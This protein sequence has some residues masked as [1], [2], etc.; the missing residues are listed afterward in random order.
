MVGNNGS[1]N[2]NSLQVTL[3]KRFSR[4]V[5]FQA[6]YTW[7][8][9]I[10]FGSGG[11]TQWPS[12]TPFY[13]AYDRGLSDFHHEHRFVTSGLWELPRLAGMS[14][15]VK[16]ILGGWQMSGAMTLQSGAPFSVNTGRENSLVGY[17]NR[18]DL[19]GDPSRSARADPNRDPVWEWFNTRAFAHNGPGTYGTSGRNIVFGPGLANVDMSVAKYFTFTERLQLQFRSEFF[20][21]F[22]RAN[23]NDPSNSIT[24]ATYGA[25]T[26]AMDPRIL[27]FGLKLMF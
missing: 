1:S 12:F 26:S 7:A 13:H 20:N 9:S 27:Q 16:W 2:F 21:L 15:P 23:F 6:N 8:K 25:I 24:S 10:D 3:D 14:A 4:G 11:G 19:V 17:G 22:N 5:T 18:A